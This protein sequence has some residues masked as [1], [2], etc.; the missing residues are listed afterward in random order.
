VVL[1]YAGKHLIERGPLARTLPLGLGFDVVLPHHG[2]RVE[3]LQP[4]GD[5]DAAAQ[6]VLRNQLGEL[7]LVTLLRLLLPPLQLPPLLR[8]LFGDQ[9]TSRVT[10]N[11]TPA[12]IVEYDS[13]LPGD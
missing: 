12:D 6:T 7:G 11:A 9:A 2:K 3:V 10:T 8:L 5:R 4:L 1:G 13:D